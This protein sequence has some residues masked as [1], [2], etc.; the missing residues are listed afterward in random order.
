LQQGSAVVIMT[1]ADA[2]LPSI[3]PHKLHRIASHRSQ[4]TAAAACRNTAD[5]LARSYS[6]AAPAAGVAGSSSVQYLAD[7]EGRESG[8][9]AA[10]E[11]A[12]D[13]DADDVG[14][15][16]RIAQVCD[17]LASATAALILGCFFQSRMI[18]LF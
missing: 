16:K 6:L 18:C 1:P 7:K 5:D 8:A 13:E 12:A 2:L 9:V 17:L 11:A 15:Q 10:H 3:P 14:V 4:I